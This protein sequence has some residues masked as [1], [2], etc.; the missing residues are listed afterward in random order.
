MEMRLSGPLARAL[1]RIPD[2]QRN[3]LLMAEVGDLTGLELAETLGVSHV[4]AR[5]SS[6]AL[7]RASARPSPTRGAWRRSAKQHSTPRLPRRHGPRTLA[8]VPTTRREPTGERHGC[9]ATGGREGPQEGPPARLGGRS[10]R[11]CPRPTPHGWRRTCV[12][13]PPASPWQTTIAPSTTSYMGWPRPNPRAI[14]GP[15]LPRAWTR[16]I[17]VAPAAPAWRAWP[18]CA[19]ATWFEIGRPWPRSWPWQ[20]W[21][22]WSGC[23]SSRR[24][25]S[26]PQSPPPPARPTSLSSVP[27]RAAARRPALTVVGGNS[28]WVA[29]RTACIRSEAAPPTARDR[30]RA[31]QSRTAR[32]QSWARSKAR[33]RCLS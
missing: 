9:G 12:A 30:R 14:C 2:R 20:W 31:A 18:V 26:S 22:W 3:A 29:P 1:A 15:G 27:P 4:A 21:Y 5:P 25:R 11:S 24:G 17:A 32:A 10:T 23:L 13:A 7:A 19:W 33:R 28:Y 16:S 6:P 8:A